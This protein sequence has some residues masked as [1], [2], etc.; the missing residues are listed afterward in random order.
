MT[1]ATFCERFIDDA[2]E[3]ILAH[4]AYRNEQWMIE[5]SENP[6]GFDGATGIRYCPVS[7]D[8]L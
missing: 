6:D 4:I 2:R 8:V 5:A 7:G 1:T 3:E